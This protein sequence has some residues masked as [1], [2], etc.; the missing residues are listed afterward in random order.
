MWL[1]VGLVVPSDRL[2]WPGKNAMFSM[3]KSSKTTS[4][5]GCMDNKQ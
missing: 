1:G 2:T 4:L 5:N 3:G